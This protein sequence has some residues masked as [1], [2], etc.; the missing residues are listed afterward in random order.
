M[1]AR[2]LELASQYCKLSNADDLFVAFDVA[3]DITADDAVDCVAKQRKRMQSMQSN[4]KYKDRAKF[5]L[6]HHRAIAAVLQKAEIYRE[7]L[8]SDRESESLPILE[9]AIDGMLIDG[10]ISAREEKYVREMAANL[11][12][13]AETAEEVLADKVKVAGARRIADGD[14]FDADN[15]PSEMTISRPI[16]RFMGDSNPPNESKQSSEAQHASGPSTGWW[17]ARFTSLLLSQI[18]PGSGQMLDVYCRMAWSALSILPR[19]KHW[20]YLGI[21]RNEERVGLARKSIAALQARARIDVG[22]PA[23]LRLRDESIDAVLAIRALQTTED[24]RPILEEAHRVLRPGGRLLVVKPDG[25]AESFY[26]NGH[27]AIYNQAF[28]HL[29]ATLDRQLNAGYADLPPTARPGLAL[30]PQLAVRAEAA[31]FSVKKVAVHAATN[32]QPVALEGLVRRLRGYP[33]ALARANGMAIDAPEVVACRTAATTLLKS[34][35]RDS[36]ARGGNTL[37]LFLCVAVKT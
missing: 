29:C 27:L 4:P 1:D 18:P 28:H 33:R 21:D 30:G 31:G 8:A 14:P 11:G 32:L 13:S 35:P 6:K 26:F 34:L 15:D 22:D 23:P 20:S 24:T 17:D 36:V 2:D 10:S 5:L 16:G 3:V 19:R 9:M 12:I 7:S 25:L 37:P